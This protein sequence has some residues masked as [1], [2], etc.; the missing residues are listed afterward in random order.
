MIMGDRDFDFS[1][2]FDEEGVTKEP[3]KKDNLKD[4]V[5]ISKDAFIRITAKVSSDLIDEL[6]EGID[7][8]MFIVEKTMFTAVYAAQ[9]TKT[10]FGKEE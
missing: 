8:P 3:P 5:T 7:D 1:F 2:I 4:S 10:I 6:A 9:L